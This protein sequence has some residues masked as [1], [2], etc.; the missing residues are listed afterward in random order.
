MILEK[1]PK[2]TDMLSRIHK[3]NSLLTNQIAAGEVIDRPASVLKELLEN[4]LDAGATEIDIDLEGGGMGQIQV[5]DNGVGI[6]PD[7]LE[8]AVEQHATSKIKEISDLEGIVSFGFRGEA[9]SAIGSV[10]KLNLQARL[11]SEKIGWRLAVEG[12]VLKSKHPA[13]MLPGTVIEVCDLFFNLPAR[14]KFLRS[15]RTE[16]IHLDEWLKRIALCAFKTT[17]RLKHNHKLVRDFRVGTIDARVAKIYG[18]TFM[19]EALQVAIEATG[20]KLWGFIGSPYFV[21]NQAQL[22]NLYVNGRWVRDKLILHAVKRAYQQKGFNTL[23]PAYLLYLEIDAPSVDVNVHP[24]KHEVRFREGRLI[25]DFISHVLSNALGQT[26]ILFEM[27]APALSQ[28]ETTS[29]KMHS[30]NLQ[31]N[32]E[33]DRVIGMVGARFLLISESQTLRAIDVGAF[34][35]KKMIEALKAQVQAGEVATRPFCIPFRASYSSTL[36]AEL[37]EFMSFLE[38]LGFKGERLPKNEILIRCAPVL[39]QDQNAQGFLEKIFQAWIE[40]NI[41]FKIGDAY[42]FMRYFEYTIDDAKDPKALF[43][44]LKQDPLFLNLM[45]ATERRID[46]A[47]LFA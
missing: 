10:A 41:A 8:L 16:F 39:M 27:P 26:Q 34:Y 13:A 6:H 46:L 4:S 5:R 35:R 14:R 22:Q 18:Q 42:E 33:A 7:D 20:L 9:L 28:A 31:L 36:A 12:G 37:A 43:E 21:C 17:F 45:D 38:Q 29:L 40:G 1:Q 30:T 3:L 47:G 32:G 15:E 19:R 44:D 25:Y 24:T 23:S 2:S 11:F